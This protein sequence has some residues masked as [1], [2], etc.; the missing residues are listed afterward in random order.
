MTYHPGAT[1]SLNGTSIPTDGSAR[2]SITGIVYDTESNDGGLIC[3]SRGKNSWYLHPKQQSIAESDRI[4]GNRD[5]RGW[6]TTRFNDSDGYQLVILQRATN[7]ALS[8]QE[9]VFTCKDDTTSIS[10]GVYYPSEHLHNRYI[11]TW[12]IVVYLEVSLMIYTYSKVCSIDTHTF[13]H[14]L[15]TVSWFMLLHLKQTFF[16]HTVKSVL[17]R[18]LVVSARNGIFK[19]N[20]TSTG[21]RALSMSVIG[22]DGFS[23]H[24]K[25]IKEMNAIQRTGNDNFC[26]TT[27]IISGRSNNGDIFQC[28]ASNGVSS[29]PT[30]IVELKGDLWIMSCKLSISI[31]FL[32]SCQPANINISEKGRCQY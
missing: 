18:I 32:S 11:D 1:L 21:G 3:R 24:L 6:H 19:V 26:A 16:F 28:I 15:H 10:V 2:I 25:Q 27:D 13:L 23:S 12:F 8:A 5:P 31:C 29:D 20:C 30:N 17:A 9:G 7:P 4:M 22:P 14:S